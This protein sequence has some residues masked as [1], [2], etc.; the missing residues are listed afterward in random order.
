[1]QSI[2]DGDKIQENRL[3]FDKALEFL[4]YGSPFCLSCT[5]VTNCQNEILRSEWTGRQVSVNTPEFRN[6]GKRD[7]W[8]HSL[9]DNE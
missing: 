8:G 4:T 6:E 9:L 7:R 2:F 3:T 5:G 1:M